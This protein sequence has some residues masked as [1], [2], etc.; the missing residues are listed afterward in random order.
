M[1]ALFASRLDARRS[2]A[3]FRVLLSAL[4]EPGRIWRLPLEGLGAAV[5][6]LSL[7]VIDSNFAVVG[8]KVQADRVRAATGASAVGLAEAALVALCG[9]VEAESIEQLRRGSAL[10]PELGAKVGVDCGRLVAGTGPDVQ[11]EVVVELSGP[12]IPGTACLGVDGV[13]PQVFVAVAQANRE[14]PA[15][16]DVW[17]V[18]EEGQVAGIPRSSRLEVR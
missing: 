3:V 1:T 15:G 8:D 2:Q 16:V 5:V 9:T 6:P 12:G 13:A 11:A 10:E 17:L 18:D 7:A 14:F 4:A